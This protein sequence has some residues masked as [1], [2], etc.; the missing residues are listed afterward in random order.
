MRGRGKRILMHTLPLLR[1]VCQVTKGYYEKEH[2][3]RATGLGIANT[4]STKAMQA[5]IKFYPISRFAVPCKGLFSFA[6]SEETTRSSVTQNIPR[7]L[8]STT[9]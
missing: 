2:L 3:L 1:N 9:A 7:P 5:A 8:L 6:L 4:R